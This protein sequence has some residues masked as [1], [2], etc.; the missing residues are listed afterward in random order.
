[1]STAVHDWLEKR[2]CP[3]H[4]VRGG[5]DGVVT[6]WELAARGLAESWPITKDEYL[7]EVDGR[8]ILADL[9]AE[10]LLDEH[11]LKRLKLAD[12]LFQGSTRAVNE[13]VWGAANASQNGWTATKNWWYFRIPA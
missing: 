9:E 5:S 10:G 6:A 11:E 2:G 1:M 3:A 13:C 4:V 12:H 7:N 8:Q